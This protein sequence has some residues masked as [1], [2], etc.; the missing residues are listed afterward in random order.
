MR[1]ASLEIEITPHAAHCAWLAEQS[2]GD[3]PS[4]SR[5]MAA[6]SMVALNRILKAVGDYALIPA[7]STGPN[8]Q[9]FYQWYTGSFALSL[10]I[11]TDS[12]VMEWFFRDLQTHQYW[13]EDW[14][15]NAPL[16]DKVLDALQVIKTTRRHAVLNAPE[17]PITEGE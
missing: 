4:I 7:A 6:L 12:V 8:G 16:P 2:C 17:T 3:S 1:R 14:N 15:V 13:G 9:M 10:D 5:D 11:P